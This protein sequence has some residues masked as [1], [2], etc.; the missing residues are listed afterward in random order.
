MHSCRHYWD[1][2]DVLKLPILS[3]FLIFLG[4]AIVFA[5]K[6]LLYLMHFVM[7]YIYY[8]I[9]TTNISSYHLIYLCHLFIFSF[10]ITLWIQK[11]CTF[12]LFENYSLAWNLLHYSHFSFLSASI[13][14]HKLL[15]L[16]PYMLYVYCP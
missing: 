11:W 13:I 5:M 9:M 6:W 14:R 15:C 12:F 7:E 10:S 4:S 3:L 1:V 8:G 16:A 2:T